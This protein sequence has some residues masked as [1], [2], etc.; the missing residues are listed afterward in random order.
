MRATIIHAAG[1]IHADEADA[2]PC[3]PWTNAAPKALL[4]P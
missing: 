1:D 4:R 3:S 2:A